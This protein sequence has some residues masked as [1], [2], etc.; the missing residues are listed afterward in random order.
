MYLVITG[1]LLSSSSIP[2]RF[3]SG[4]TPLKIIG[5]LQL[6]RLCTDLIQI[7]ERL[8]RR[9]DGIGWHWEGFPQA[10]YVHLGE[11]GEQ[12]LAQ[13]WPDRFAVIQK[14]PPAGL[15]LQMRV[16]FLDDTRRSINRGERPAIGF[17]MVQPGPSQDGVRRLRM[18]LLHVGE[19][20]M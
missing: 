15:A 8:N 2:T 11:I 14:L 18:G 20:G 19:Q 6:V 1:T 3:A 12:L 9:L 5:T 17:E 7:I 16:A 10:W 4:T 13:P